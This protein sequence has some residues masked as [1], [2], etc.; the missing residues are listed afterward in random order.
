MVS[1]GDGWVLNKRLSNWKDR[2]GM[3]GR[4]VDCLRARPPG[5]EPLPSLELISLASSGVPPC[6]GPL[7]SLPGDLAFPAADPEL[8]NGMGRL[9]GWA[10]RVLGRKATP[11]RGEGSQKLPRLARYTSG[12]AVLIAPDWVE[13]L[14]PALTWSV[15]MRL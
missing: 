9:E 8:R 7:K 3:L 6:R 14:H 2:K 5:P 4:R 1:L 11:K 13:S 10:E 15:F 12:I